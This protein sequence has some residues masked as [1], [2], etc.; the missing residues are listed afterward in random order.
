MINAMGKAIGQLVHLGRIGISIRM[1]PGLCQ[2]A[3]TK[4]ETL[5]HQKVGHETQ[6]HNPPSVRILKPAVSLE[7]VP[8]IL[9]RGKL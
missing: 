8:P 6:L 5:S 9:F 1:N 4:L 7:K 3:D 2:I